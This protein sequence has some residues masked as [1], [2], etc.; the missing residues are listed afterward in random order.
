MSKESKLMFRNAAIAFA[1]LAF[2]SYAGLEIYFFILKPAMNE[3][4]PIGEPTSAERPVLRDTPES[5]PVPES[6]APIDSLTIETNY[7][8]YFSDADKCRK[9]YT[10]MFG[11]TTGAFSDNSACN[12]TVTFNRSGKATKSLVIKRFD[13]GLQ[14]WQDVERSDRNGRVE[15]GDFEKLAAA[16]AGND[17]FKSWNDNMSVTTGNVSITA[18]YA[19]GFVKSP[20]SNVAEGTTNFPLM[21]DA[22]RELD[23]KIAW[24]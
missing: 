18:K 13:P 21:I 24:R 3:V 11:S 22:F 9:T 1:A 10:E 20:K 7:V 2:L 8:G 5:K 17:A 19:D 14:R 16:V 15:P 4:A 6:V 12:V 23:G